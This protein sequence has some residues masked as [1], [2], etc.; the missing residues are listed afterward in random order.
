[1]SDV[2][3][4]TEPRQQMQPLAGRHEGRGVLVSG[5]TGAVGMAVAKRFLAE[6]ARVWIMGQSTDSVAR[7]IGE[8]GATGGCVCDVTRER[9]VDDAVA[10]ARERLG[11]IDAVFVGAGIPGDGRDVLGIDAT[12]FRRVVDV[13][14]TGAFLVAR[15]AAR[16]MG[17]GGA[18]VFNSAAVGMVAEPGQADLAASKAGV[19]MIAK[20]MALDLSPRGVAVMAVCPGDVRT[21]SIEARLADPLIA[22]EHLSRIPAGRLG[23]PDEVAG[24]VAFLCSREAAYLTGSAIAVDGGRTAI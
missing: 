18:I 9:D 14:L 19:I 16:H 17:E 3:A 24:L 4:I 22:A 15:A 21:P 1:M 8:T 13:N 12:T 5:G 7:A 10:M 20:T 6:G 23:E 2:A 11:T